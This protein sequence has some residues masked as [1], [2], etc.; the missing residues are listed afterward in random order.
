[1]S[2]PQSRRASETGGA[3]S[4]LAATLL[5]VAAR[6]R[7][8]VDEMGRH[9][10][11]TAVMWGIVRFTFGSGTFK[12]D[13]FIFVHFN[14]PNVAAV[15]RGRCSAQRAHVAEA[16]GP[17]H[18]DLEVSSAA[19]CATDLFFEKLNRTFVSDSGTVSLQEL[20]AQYVNS[21]MQ[22]AAAAPKVRPLAAEMKVRAATVLQAIR[23]PTGPFNWG[24]F[25]PTPEE[26]KLYNGG[27]LS[28]PELQRALPDN[29][30]L[31]GLIRMGFGAGPFRRTKWVFLHWV[32]GQT[33]AVKRGRATAAKGA[34]MDLLKPFHADVE[35]DSKTDL[36]LKAFVDRMT[37]KFVVDDDGSSQTVA[38]ESTFGFDSFL[39]A[40]AE[41]QAANAA[42]FDDAPEPA[43][44]G[45][46]L[47]VEETLQLVRQSHSPINWALFVLK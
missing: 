46:T 44:T 17:F 47:E 26:L 11:D 33:G 32:G 24:L 14:G 43:P 9:C 36:D 10:D 34:M 16:L 42:F 15:K 5:R 7:G 4:P 21:V 22:S 20:K 8:G 2:Q 41:E 30:V 12:R 28:V 39:A 6:G 37:R 3:V 40:L 19:E 18:A 23:Q 45:Q 25:E 35:V 27:S 13:K 31:Y 38:G 29:Q 1:M